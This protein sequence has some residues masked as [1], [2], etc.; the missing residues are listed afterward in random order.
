MFS[1]N[2]NPAFYKA[3]WGASA[4]DWQGNAGRPV[5]Q[6]IME[7]NRYSISEFHSEHAIFIPGERNR[8]HRGEGRLKMRP[9]GLDEGTY[10]GSVDSRFKYMYIWQYPASATK[11]RFVPSRL[12]VSMGEYGGGRSTWL[13]RFTD[14]GEWKPMTLNIALNPNMSM[15]DN[16]LDGDVMWSSLVQPYLPDV[17][18]YYEKERGEEIFQETRGLTRGKWYFDVKMLDGSIMTIE[19]ALGRRNGGLAFPTNDPRNVGF[20]VI[21]LHAPL[22]CRKNCSLLDKLISSQ[23]LFRNS[24]FTAACSRLKVRSMVV[25]VLPFTEKTVTSYA[26]GVAVKGITFIVGL[27][28][29]SVNALD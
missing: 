13:K 17:L 7:E 26:Y 12:T 6:S 14:K 25:G 19:D 1:H 27:T 24:H 9:G 29:S 2:G 22:E 11:G 5:L 10:K 20:K 18:A 23:Y 4:K 15:R 21:I 8:L 3:Q 16:I 28:I